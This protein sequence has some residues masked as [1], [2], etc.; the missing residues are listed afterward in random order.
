K[1][2]KKSDSVKLSPPTLLN[3]NQVNINFKENEEFDSG[4]PEE[5]G[6]IKPRP[7]EYENLITNKDL[8]EIPDSDFLQEKFGEFLD[9]WVEISANKIEESI[10][11]NEKKKE[12][13]ILSSAIQDITHLAID[14]SAKWDLR[15]L[16]NKL[17]LP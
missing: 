7:E 14:Y 15:S 12:N 3:N 13:E 8:D 5:S 2:A 6:E 10:D 16:F 11:A 4:E 17:Q 1:H 9:I